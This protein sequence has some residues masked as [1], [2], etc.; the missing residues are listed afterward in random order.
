MTELRQALTTLVVGDRVVH[1]RVDRSGAP[2]TI[3]VNVEVDYERSW[4]F[5]EPGWQ[6]VAFGFSEG[7]L[8]WWSARHVVLVPLDEDQGDAVMVSADE[9]IR[10]AFAVPEGWLLVCETSVRL[11]VDGEGGV[12]A[13]TR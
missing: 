3:I 5:D 6:D 2:R 10:F 8:Y 4:S 12:A 7:R 13:R 9:D 11:V 1:V